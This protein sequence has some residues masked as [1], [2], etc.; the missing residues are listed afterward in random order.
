MITTGERAFIKVGGQRSGAIHRCVALHPTV[1]FAGFYYRVNSGAATP[2]LQARNSTQP[3][4]S[5]PAVATRTEHILSG[6]LDIWQAAFGEDFGPFG[7]K[8]SY[9]FLLGVS[10]PE[11]MFAC[12]PRI[13]GQEKPGWG[14]WEFRQIK[15][16]KGGEGKSPRGQ[17]GG[18]GYTHTHACGTYIP[19]DN[20]DCISTHIYVRQLCVLVLHIWNPI[21][22][23]IIIP[24]PIPPLRYSFLTLHSLL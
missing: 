18:G 17:R 20:G 24:S 5:K 10:R 2:G 6:I 15:A 22:V 21:C 12:I 1:Q 9:K 7:C 19:N 14:R 4:Q 3:P 13:P 11:E 23:I 8:T 16:G